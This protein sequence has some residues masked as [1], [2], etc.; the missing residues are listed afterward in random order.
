MVIKGYNLTFGY[1]YE[2]T[3]ISWTWNVRPKEKIYWKT[4]KPKLENVKILTDLTDEKQKRIIAK[5]IFEGVLNSEH[6]IKDK[7]TGIYG[8]RK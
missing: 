7:L 8:V 2:G 3:N 5:E 4:W 1:D 6:P